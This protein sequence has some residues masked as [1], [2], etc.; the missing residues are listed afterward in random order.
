MQTRAVIEAAIEVRAEKGFDI[1][2]EIMIPLVGD[3]KELA[4]VRKIVMETAEKVMT[5]RTSRSTS[6]WAR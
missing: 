4:F 5:R 6:R 2:P 1:H 3:A